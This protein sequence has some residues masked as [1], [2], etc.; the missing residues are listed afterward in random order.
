MGAELKPPLNLDEEPADPLH[1]LLQAARKRWR[2]DDARSGQRRPQ[3]PV[4]RVHG[5]PYSRPQ[6]GMGA[7]RHV[8]EFA[9]WGV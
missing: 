5:P 3:E 1:R 4:Q 8:V 2:D 9:E 6:P 7:L